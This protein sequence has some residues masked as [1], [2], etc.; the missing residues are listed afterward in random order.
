MAT[1][2]NAN[3]NPDARL[4]LQVAK[5]HI[6]E[7]TYHPT[8]ERILDATIVAIE[9]NG[10][11]GV[12][13]AD[14]A[15]SLDMTIPAMYRYFADREELIVA[16]RARRNDQINAASY[17]LLVDTVASVTTAEQFA[18]TL[19]TVVDLLLNSARR[20]EL[21]DT[22]EI[23]AKCRHNPALRERVHALHA[24]NKKLVLEVLKL[25]QARRW[26]DPGVDVDVVVNLFEAIAFGQVTWYLSDTEPDTTALRS[27]VL[28]LL[29]AMLFISDD[30]A[31][32]APLIVAAPD[33]P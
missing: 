18:D 13:L 25:A 24:H 20:D 9:A 11:A 14:I 21:L 22:C 5:L 17:R 29:G 3:H 19:N 8:A 23:V 33:T 26:V 16:A 10:E 7:V 28:D 32:P 27:S 31:D 2:V 6:D 30:G 1:T 4:P 12:R 15:R